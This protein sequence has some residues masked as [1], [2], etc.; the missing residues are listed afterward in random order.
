MEQREPEAG[1]MTG[2]AWIEAVVAS[3]KKAPDA[4]Q[5]RSGADAPC[6]LEGETPMSESDPKVNAAP[7]MPWVKSYCDITTLQPLLDVPAFRQSRPSAR[8][9]RSGS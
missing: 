7:R 1:R 2:R 6:Y 3:M 9:A 5:G 4:G 8:T